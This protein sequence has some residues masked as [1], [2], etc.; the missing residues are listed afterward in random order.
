MAPSLNKVFLMGNLTREPA[1]RYTPGGSAV[2]D[3]AIAVNRKFTVGQEQRE[4][5]CFVDIT[6]WG[7]SAE[8]CSRY[9]QKGSG[10]LVEGR[11]QME[12]WTDK[13]TQ[14]KRSRLRVVAENFQFLGK[15]GARDE[16]SEPQEEYQDDYQQAPPP[17]PPRQSAPPRQSSYQQSSQQYRGNQQAPQR[18]QPPRQEAPKMPE[19]AFDVV[20]DVE[21][22]IPF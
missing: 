20:E 5:A 9:L 1:L 14:K 21:D 2:C 15:G 18:Q 17:P 10:I 19:D 8:T 11:L 13:E 12:Q 3:F 16:N 4:E 6:V 22:D 7:K